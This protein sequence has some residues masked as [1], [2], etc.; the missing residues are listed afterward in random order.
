MPRG[1][2]E[3]QDRELVQD[4]LIFSFVPFIKVNK[5]QA[6]TGMC[7]QPMATGSLWIKIISSVPVNAEKA[8]EKRRRSRPAAEI[9][10]DF[11]I[12]VAGLFPVQCVLLL[13]SSGEC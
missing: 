9:S 10:V 3:G 11:S 6:L 5:K 13:T 1:K 4:K 12:P 8:E 2:P 7:T